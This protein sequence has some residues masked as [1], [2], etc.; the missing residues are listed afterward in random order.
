MRRPRRE[1]PGGD[2][3][4]PDDGAGIRAA[5]GH[6]P[7]RN[8]DGGPGLLRRRGAGPGFRPRRHRHLLPGGTGLVVQSG[9]I[10]G[11]L[12]EHFSR[13]GMGISSFAS[14][15]GKLDV[16]GTD[17][18]LWWEADHTTELAILHLES[19]GDPRRFART[20]RR[21]SAKF[22]VLTVHAGWSAPGQRAFASHTASAVAPLITRMALFEQAG[23]IATA[24]FGELLDAAVLLASQPVPA[25]NVV[26]IVS[27]C[28][29]TGVLAAGA[30]ANAGLVVA[31]TGAQASH[32]AAGGAACRGI[33]GR[34]GG[35]Y[36]G[37]QPG[38][39]R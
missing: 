38:G 2:N 22:P 8:A 34:P 14:V 31:A 36:R 21:V 16:S 32:P 18:L 29:G 1:V 23:I 9:G 7:G 33:P 17:M 5:R 13:L 28:V 30:C 27:S 15:G 11:A 19:F 37:R 25:G 39:L 35:R 6:P 12:L 26:A 20:A 4:G 24:S 3:R 10:G